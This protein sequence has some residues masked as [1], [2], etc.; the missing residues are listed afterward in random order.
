[1]AIERTIKIKIDSSGAKRNVDSLDSSM[2]GLGNSADKTDKSFG[3]LKATVI[4]VAAALQVAVVAKYADAFTSLQNQIRQTTTTTEQLTNRTAT[5]LEVANRSRAGFTETADLYTQLTLATENLNL[6]TDQQIRLT[7]TISKSFAVSGKSAAESSGAIRQLGQA[8][9]AGA[10]RGDEFNSIAEGAPELMRALQRSLKLTAGELRAFAATGG[11]TAEIMVNAFGKAADVIDEKMTNSVETLAQSMVIAENNAIAFVGASDLITTSMGAAGESI[12]FLSENLDTVANVLLVAATIGVSKLSAALIINTLETVKN[13]VAKVSGSKA[14]IA[15]NTGINFTTKSLSA[16]TVA[17]RISTVPATGLKG[18]M[19]FLGGPL[20]VVFLA[21][22]AIAIFSTN[23][24]DAKTPTEKLAEEVDNLSKSFSGLSDQ[25][26]FAQ[27]A[28]NVAKIISLNKELTVKVRS[29][30]SAFGVMANEAIPQGTMAI[31][32]QNESVKDL[33]NSIS[34]LEIANEALFKVGTDKIIAAAT[35][36]TGLTGVKKPKKEDD[37]FINNERFKTASLRAELNERL[38]VQR[39]FN[40]LALSDFESIGEQERAIA[41]FNRLAALASLEKAKVQSALDFEQRREAILIND[42]LTSEARLVLNA[43]LELQELDQRRLFELEKTAIEQ[44]GADE[45]AAITRA[46][47]SMKLDN[48]QSFGQ[49]A[50]NLNEIFGSKSEKAQKKRKKAIIHMNA[51]AGIMRAWGEHE[52]YEALGMTIA[53]AASKQSQLAA[54]EGGGSASP[55]VSIPRAQAARQEPL[56][57]VTII[58]NRGLSEVAALLANLDPGE[59][60]PVEYTQ[61]IIASLEQNERL[62]GG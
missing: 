39:A 55:T 38:A 17:M 10:L 52:F 43:E 14:S 45:R 24:E 7:E 59:V 18:A 50:L 44:E 8:F 11:I 61:R 21:A 6:S 22:S 3:K 12:V 9:S 31:I 15:V 40:E 32:N 5:L 54:L 58:E 53:I 4:A 60:L 2:K 57:Q 35:D 27:T 47:F 62:G 23:A 56:E 19:A 34:K 42:K 28:N 26:R 1:M 41:E 20:G 13:T 25:A 36:Q 30:A 51:A 48:I 29:L 37:P 16:Q 49:T 33:I 46:E